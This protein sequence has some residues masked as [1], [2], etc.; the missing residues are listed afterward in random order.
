[1]EIYE[2]KYGLTTSQ[3]VYGTV[4]ENRAGH[5]PCYLKTDEITK[6]QALVFPLI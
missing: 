1:M 5:G 3:R 6:E 4:M 2:T